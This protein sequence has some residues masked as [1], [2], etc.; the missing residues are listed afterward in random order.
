M[1]ERDLGD[2]PGRVEAMEWRGRTGPF[3]LALREGVF[4][5]THTSL[6]LA[7][8]LEVRSGDAVADIGCGC[9]I[10]GI[11]AARLGA[12]SVV[13]T[14][15]SPG[16]IEVAAG[17]ARSLGVDGI[18]QFRVGN[19]CEPLGEERFDVVIGDVSGVPDTLA[20]ATGWLPGGGPTGAEQPVALLE[21]V[22]PSLRP[23]G[24]LYLPTGSLQDDR[25]VLTA[26][27]R[28][29]GPDRLDL[30]ETRRFP[31]AGPVATGP[32]VAD[33]T[34]AGVVRL[35]TRGTRRLW[36]LNLWCCRA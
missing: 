2:L 11:V 13:G 21:A 10:L 3:A 12:A 7:D 35:E 28:I 8:A 29:F 1:R 15:I 36:E 23:G 22:R 9:G 33:L 16:A 6:A 31:L 34:A 26:A 4:V 24:R 19:L 30:L 5:P 32:A 18:C 20:E 14:D 17:N 25:Q 27:R